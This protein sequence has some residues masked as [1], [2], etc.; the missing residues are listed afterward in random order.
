MADSSP[1]VAINTEQK[2]P[3]TIKQKSFESTP[4]NVFSVPV[5]L[6]YVPK[7]NGTSLGRI[8]FTYMPLTVLN[9]TFKFVRQMRITTKAH[10]R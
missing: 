2:E 6:F 8:L 3:P 10:W 7:V 1:H 9:P 4:L 5:F